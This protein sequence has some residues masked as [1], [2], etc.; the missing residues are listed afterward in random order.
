MC[1]PMHLPCFLANGNYF[2]GGMINC[3][4]GRLV[5]N[6]FF[7]TFP[8]FSIEELRGEYRGLH[9]AGARYYPGKNQP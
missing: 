7:M 4:N 6:Y 3:Y 2:P 1:F 5:N 9:Q 8:K